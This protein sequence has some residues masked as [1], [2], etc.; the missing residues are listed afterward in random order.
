MTLLALQGEVESAAAIRSCGLPGFFTSATD[1]GDFIK[2]AVA[3][4]VPVAASE[5]GYANPRKA[6]VMSSAA[7]C[8]EATEGSSGPS[9][10][11]RGLE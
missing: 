1:R 8:A 10:W 5:Y 4:A 3:V 2:F 7:S 9:G 6:E 11:R